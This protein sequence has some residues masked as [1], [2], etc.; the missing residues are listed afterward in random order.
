M[1]LVAELGP[2]E[3]ENRLYFLN[4]LE[5]LGIPVKK[6][7]KLEKARYTRF[8]TQ[9]M[10]I[11]KWDDLEELAQ[12]MLELYNSSEFTLLRKQVAS[13]LKGKNPAK[14]IENGSLRNQAQT[15]KGNSAIYQAFRKWMELNGISPS[16]YRVTTRN[17]SFKIPLFD[18]F[19]EKLGETREKWWWHNGPF[20][21]WMNFS[22]EELYFTLEIGPIEPIKRVQLMENLQEQGIHFNKRGLSPGAKYTRI[23]TKTVQTEG[24]NEDQFIETFEEIYKNRE[25][26]N[27]LKTLELIYDKFRDD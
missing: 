11:N 16:N 1:R 10:D 25:L 27:I 21:F 7:S 9:K 14:S 23:Y 18:Q 13:I 8:Y 26:Q 12:G 22:N 15:Q 19:K 24:F 6:S 20:L 4:K 2:I 3:Y 5:K 17:V